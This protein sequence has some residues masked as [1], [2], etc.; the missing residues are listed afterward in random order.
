MALKIEPASIP[1]ERISEKFQK[2]TQTAASLNAESDKLS[3]FIEKLEKALRALNLGVSAWVTVDNWEDE[4]KN[5]RLSE[6]GYDKSNIGAWGLYLRASVLNDKGM[7][8]SV[9]NWSF[10]SAPRELRVR[11][12]SHI[13]ELIVA[14]NTTA[15]N[16]TQVLIQGNK[17]AEE[18]ATALGMAAG[19]D[20]DEQALQQARMEAK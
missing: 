6:V 17:E 7:L 8:V 13:P 12:I 4:S 16:V 2:L 18:L 11:A 3:V 9:S 20:R 19:I 15:S 1:T 10:T 5:K 14:L